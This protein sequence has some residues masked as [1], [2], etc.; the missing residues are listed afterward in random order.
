[1]KTPQSFFLAKERDMSW[2]QKAVISNQR[3]NMHKNNVCVPR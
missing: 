2:L 1:M 3:A